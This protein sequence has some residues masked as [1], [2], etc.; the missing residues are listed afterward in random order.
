MERS[1]GCLAFHGR[2]LANSRPA[3]RQHDFHMSRITM[4]TE[5]FDSFRASNRFQLSSKRYESASSSTHHVPIDAVARNGHVL[6]SHSHGMPWT[7]SINPLYLH[8]YNDTTSK[9]P[10]YMPFWNHQLAFMKHHLTNLRSIPVVSS[11]GIDMSYAVAANDKARIHTCAFESDEYSRIRMTILDAGYNTQVFSSL[12]YPRANLPVFGIDLLQFND[13][14]HLCVMDFQ[15]IHAKEEDHACRYEDLLGAIR[16]KYPL[17][18]EKMTNRFYV[19]SQHFSCNTLLGRAP[20]RD[21]GYDMVWT[22]VMPAFQE[23]LLAHLALTLQ[24]TTSLAD[25]TFAQQG[26]ADYDTYSAARDPAHAMLG[27]MFGQEWADDFLYDVLFPNAK[28]SMR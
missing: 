28:R 2:P 9:I 4:D 3:R 1:R 13:C 23:C 12:F 10:F 27:K 8:S 15:P 22:Q 18:Q 6:G 20:S 11:E 5:D 21:E 16:L 7:T 26:Q 17:L 14:K 19:D 24:A 25:A